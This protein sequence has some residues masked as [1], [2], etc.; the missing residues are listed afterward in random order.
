MRQR[1]ATAVAALTLVMAGTAAC[2]GESS[3]TDKPAD[4]KK[5][6]RQ[7]TAPVSPHPAPSG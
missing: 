1:T 6:E 2:G 7:Y 3:G 5:P 4:A